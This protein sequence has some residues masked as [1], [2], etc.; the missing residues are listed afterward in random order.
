MV[1]TTRIPST[2]KLPQLF[3]NPDRSSDYPIRYHRCWPRRH[4]SRICFLGV[5]ELVPR[6]IHS[7]IY[8]GSSPRTSPLRNSKNATI[9]LI[10]GQ[11]RHCHKTQ[12]MKRGRSRRK[13]RGSPAS[14]SIRAPPNALI[15]WYPDH[16]ALY[17]PLPGQTELGS[18]GVQPNKG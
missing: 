16:I 12:G 1:G 3:S 18:A 15:R 11:C 13:R 6:R 5:H 2:R 10:V 17:L 7:T 4:H 8:S 9:H 14:H